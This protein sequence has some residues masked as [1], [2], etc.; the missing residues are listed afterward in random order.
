MDRVYLVATVL[1]FIAL[2]LVFFLPQIPLR[3]GKHASLEEGGLE[4][5]TGPG[6]QA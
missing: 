2:A 6:A 5:R 4:E 1:M 3:K